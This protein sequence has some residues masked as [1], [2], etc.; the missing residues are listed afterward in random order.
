MGVRRAMHSRYLPKTVENMQSLFIHAHGAMK[1]IMTPLSRLAL[2]LAAFCM[3]LLGTIVCLQLVTRLF[4]IPL[5]WGSDI[6]G[7][8][9]VA[10]TFMAFAPTLRNAV[11]VRV[12]LIM[13]SVSSRG[14][15]W[16]QLWSFGLG[17]Y[18]AFYAARWS[19]IQVIESYRFKDVTTGIIPFPLWIPQ[20]FMAAGF[21]IFTLAML[22][23]LLAVIA[24][25]EPEKVA[26]DIEMYSGD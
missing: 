11:H 20:S 3:L 23:G 12:H 14:K 26:S 9:L 22:E 10:T 13:E 5:V 7:F 2:W 17:L 25:V 19:V 1:Y 16:L 8:L 15:Q 21:V 24:G 4:R 18:F 6:A